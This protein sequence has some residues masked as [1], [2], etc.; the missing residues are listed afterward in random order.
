MCYK[1]KQYFNTKSNVNRNI[2]ALNVSM[3]TGENAN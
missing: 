1:K 2:Q 3:I